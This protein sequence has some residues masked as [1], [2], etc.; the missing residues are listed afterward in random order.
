MFWS[1]MHSLLQA[2]TALQWHES[3]PIVLDCGPS[4]CTLSYKGL[5]LVYANL[6]CTFTF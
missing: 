6:R 5:E 1:L 4:A 3:M 2:Y